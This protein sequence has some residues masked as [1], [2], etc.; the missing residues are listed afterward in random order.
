MDANLILKSRRQ[1]QCR[2][3]PAARDVLKRCAMSF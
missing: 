1:E 2:A 3:S